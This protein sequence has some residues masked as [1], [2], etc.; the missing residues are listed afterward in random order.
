MKKNLLLISVNL[1]IPFI[2][3]VLPSII[4]TRQGTSQTEGGQLLSFVKDK[5]ITFS[6]I[7]DRPNLSS[8]SIDFKN[9]SLANTSSI[10]FNIS[11]S[12]STKSLSFSGANI[13]DPS[14]V[15]LK[16]P[17]FNDP[18]GTKYTVTLTTLNVD[19]NSLYLV[20]NDQQQPVFKSYYHQTNFQIKFPHLYYNYFY[21]GLILLLNYLII[22]KA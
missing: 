18:V 12:S 1:L 6:F 13:G 19:P 21:L 11:N 14:T 16:F 17:E 9:P 7:S 20:V 8:L 15:P 10:E 3:V 2:L 4:T 5:P 22:K